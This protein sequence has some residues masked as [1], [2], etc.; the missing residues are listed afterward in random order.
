VVGR[1][2]HN[3]GVSATAGGRRIGDTGSGAGEADDR[4]GATTP[5]NGSVTAPNAGPVARGT[6]AETD[7]HP[8]AAEAA[9]GARAAGGGGA[10]I[11]GVG[12]VG[13]VGAAGGGAAGSRLEHRPLAGLRL[14]IRLRANLAGRITLK[15]AV[16]ILGAIV[17]AVGILLIPL[18]GPGWVIVL[19]GLAIWSVEFAWAGRLLHF[20]RRQLAR[21]WH[22]M[23]RRSPVVRLLVGAAGLL[24]IA[25]IVWA[26]VR[27]S[28]GVDLIE[29]GWNLATTG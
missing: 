24:I 22:W 25:A 10:G 27:L 1:T 7:G 16:A 15:V 5:S 2:D 3:A 19:G 28:T 26:A 8:A 9:T 21:W 18:P 29:L 13:G 20:T 17:V 23:A 6:T 11:A 12:G 4:E 14:I